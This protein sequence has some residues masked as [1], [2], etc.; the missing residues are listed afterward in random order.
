[1]ADKK[2]SNSPNN[3]EKDNQN[4]QNI[5]NSPSM[6]NYQSMPQQNT[7][8]QQAIDF[9]KIKTKLDNFKKL[10]LKKYN[11][12]ISLSILPGQAAPIIEEDEGIPKEVSDTRP[13]YVLMTIPEEKYK[14]I[15]KIKPEIIKL[16]KET[17]EN[18]WI[19]IKTPIDLWNYGLDSK[20]E[21]LD[22]VSASFP[23]Y[24]NG[25][26]GAL[27]VANIHK[28]LVL[29]KFE[30][31]VTSYV[32][33]GSLVRGTAS[34]DS[35]VDVFV[36]IDDTDVKRMP[37]L[38][39]LDK[40]RGI[41]YDYIR[42]ATAL[43]GVKNIL[44]VQVYLLTDFWQSVKDAHP[45][46]FTFIRNGIPLYDRGTF[47]PWKRLLKMGRIKPSPEAIDLYMKQGDQTEEMV[48]RR[49]LDAMVDIY[50]GVVTPTQALMMLAGEAPPVP[51][52]IV[53]DVRKVLVQKDKVLKEEDLKTLERAVYLF[54]QYEYGKLKEIPGKD[55]DEFLSN[56]KKYNFKLKSIRQKIEKTMNEK[57]VEDLYNNLFKLLS[58]LFGNKSQKELMSD[59][60]SKMVK[61][62][63]IQPRFSSM[64]KEIVESRKKIKSGKVTASQADNIKKDAIELINAIVEYG[65][66]ADLVASEKGTMQ[67][68]YQNRKAELVLFG[69]KNFLVEGKDIKK[70][71]GGKLHPSSKEELEKALAENKGKLHTSVSIEVFKTL[72]KELGNFEITF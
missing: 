24:D 21:M 48:K 13:L 55:I 12:T 64:L 38:E 67:I 15:P 62:G 16:V 32:V 6:P 43:S 51:K 30:K 42:E 10:V 49:L 50:Y 60:E 37:S 18:L 56:C 22:I 53:D 27:R 61:K 46:M 25:F 45:V 1:M 14:E 65:Q 3:K 11:F 52:T 54:K 59:F 35:D 9:D 44:N 58:T 47:I 28:S 70:I 26:L 71:E 5:T 2:V 33:G 19:L 4:L 66:R 31:Y 68:T 29:R 63:K 36:V 57:G 69:Q 8:S 72:E 20:F 17:K 39:L 40:L 34:K 23:L 41:I 7:P